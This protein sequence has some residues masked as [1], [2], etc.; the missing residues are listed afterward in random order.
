[1]G[2]GKSSLVD[3]IQEGVLDS[4]VSLADTLRKCVTLGGQAN[5]SGL[6]DWARREL[7]GYGPDDELPEWRKVPAPIQVDF[8]NTRFIVRGQQISTWDLPDFA[9][10]AYKEEV[11][12]RSG[13]GELEAL[14]RQA[15]NGIV[16][17]G[18]PG[19]SELLTYINRTNNDT[20]QKIERIYW[21]LSIAAIH[22]IL[23]RIRNSLADRV[24]EL[25]HAMSDESTTTSQAVSAPFSI[26][27]QR[28][29][30]TINSAQS[31]G[32]GT[33]T[34]GQSREPDSDWMRWAKIIGGVIVGVATILG[35]IF[36][37]LQYANS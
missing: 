13:V 22:S 19:G 33:S 9:R 3:Q 6:R 20:H 24:G 1:V 16:R 17:L 28:N 32:G 7:N 11:E 12:L 26:S 27:G 29:R 35:T 10:D 21:A 30:V 5:S 34:I 2:R 23:E 18:L 25:R 4:R 36:A 37:W 8:L 15:D 14:L 31:N